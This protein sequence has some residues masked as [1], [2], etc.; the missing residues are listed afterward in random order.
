[1]SVHGNSFH[2]PDSLLRYRGTSEALRLKNISTPVPPTPARWPGA[3]GWEERAAGKRT[4][5]HFPTAPRQSI[6]KLIG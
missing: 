2:G 5:G 3:V 1:M 6:E 4:T